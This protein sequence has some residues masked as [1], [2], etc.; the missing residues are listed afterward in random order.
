MLCRRQPGY[1]LNSGFRYPVTSEAA[2][3]RYGVVCDMQDSP[4]QGDTREGLFRRG[5][6]P[7]IN[8]APADLCK[9]GP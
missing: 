1:A 8:N 7:N 3:K 4:Q 9:A 5:S 2:S 6:S